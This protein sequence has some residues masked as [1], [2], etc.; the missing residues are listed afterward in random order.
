MVDES[1]DCNDPDCFFISLKYIFWRLVSPKSSKLAVPCSN[2][3]P[4]FVKLSLP[5]NILKGLIVHVVLCAWCR[6]TEFCLL[7]YFSISFDWLRRQNQV[8]FRI[9]S[10]GIDASIG[11]SIYFIL[12]VVFFCESADVLLVYFFMFFNCYNIV[13]MSRQFYDSKNFAFFSLL[14]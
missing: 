7:I 14:T 1:S 13:Q 6:C 4:N 2:S 11:V 12:L 5:S 10:K 3:S 9:L 8:D